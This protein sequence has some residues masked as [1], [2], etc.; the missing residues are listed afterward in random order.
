L[1][2]AAALYL[3]TALDIAR[4]A[5][6]KEYPFQDLVTAGRQ[7][8][9]KE[10]VKGVLHEDGLDKPSIKEVLVII[11]FEERHSWGHNLGHLFEHKFSLEVLALAVSLVH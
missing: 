1:F 10:M 2:P 6:A 9:V 4:T 11:F 7:D 3:E 8:A 5:V